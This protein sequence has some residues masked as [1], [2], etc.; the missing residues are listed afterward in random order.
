LVRLKF[1]G[2]VTPL[3][4]AVTVYGPP[5]VVLAVKVDEVAMPLEFVVAVVVVEE[6]ANVPEAPEPGA[7]KVTVTPGTPSPAESVTVA[8]SGAVKAVK[9][10]ADWDEPEETLID[11]GLPMTVQQLLVVG[12]R[13]P[14][15]SVTQT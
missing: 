9:T 2:F 14:A 4:L 15:W 1:A 13:L 3:T 7:V 5:A 6:L 12:E 11:A 10:V 8:A